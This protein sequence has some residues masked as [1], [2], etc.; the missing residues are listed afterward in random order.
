MAA[1]A[2]QQQANSRLRWRA[3]TRL[4]QPLRGALRS[5]VHGRAHVRPCVL[6]LHRRH[7]RVL[8]DA[9]H[10][11]ALPRHRFAVGVVQRIL[12]CAL[13]KVVRLSRQLQTCHPLNERAR[14]LA[15]PP[16]AE[17]GVW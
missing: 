4:V 13:E 15:A 12:R 1:S 14:S 6:R 9:L 10:R 3:A 8:R 7:V 11:A 16:R 2:Q 5:E 17:W